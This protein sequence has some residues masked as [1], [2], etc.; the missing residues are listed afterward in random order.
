LHRPKTATS[1]QSVPIEIGI[2][3]SR[4]A[5]FDFRSLPR[6]LLRLFVVQIHS[7]G[8]QIRL[9]GFNLSIFLMI[10]DQLFQ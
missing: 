6:N 4:M 5:I 9:G 3:G 10:A 1:L 8:R 2:F 7:L